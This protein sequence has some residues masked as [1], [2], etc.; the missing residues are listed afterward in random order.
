MWRGRCSSG[1]ALCAVP[2]LCLLA[3]PKVADVCLLEARVGA[4]A[5]AQELE[6]KVLLVEEA[7]A[8]LRDGHVDVGDGGLVERG[9]HAREFG[10]ADVDILAPQRPQRSGVGGDAH[11]RVGALLHGESAV[12]ALAKQVVVALLVVVAH[13]HDIRAAD[14][15]FVPSPGAAAD[16]AGQAA[17]RRRLA[18]ELFCFVVRQARLWQELDQRQ[19]LKVEERP[20]ERVAAGSA[21]VAVRSFRVGPRGSVLHHRVQQS[22][23]R[24]ASVA[25]W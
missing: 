22:V 15:S 14:G 13:A 16:A 20:D 19:N 8:G 18:H 21:H 12:D 2:P 4:L 17:V 3:G 10:R 5:V 9:A 11:V 24:T 23:G 6:L 7:V 1:R 25:D